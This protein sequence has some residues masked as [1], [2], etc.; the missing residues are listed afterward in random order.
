MLGVLAGKFNSVPVLEFFGRFYTVSLQSLG[1]DSK[2]GSP[3]RFDCVLHLPSR[4]RLEGRGVELFT[5]TS[6]LDQ[7]MVD[8]PEQKAAPIIAFGHSLSL[9]CRA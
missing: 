3:G 7:R 2:L 5:D 4:H 1:E 8:V 6:C 9:P